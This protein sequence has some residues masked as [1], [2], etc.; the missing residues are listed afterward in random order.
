MPIIQINMVHCLQ[1]VSVMTTF[2]LLM[3][4]HPDIQ[5]R[6]QKEVDRV[7]GGTMVTPDDTSS[8]PLV[9]A[10]IKEIKRWGPVAPLGEHQGYTYVITFE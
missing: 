6:A 9:N 4:L 5:K 1:T 10:V 8:L 3:T 2:F 7:M